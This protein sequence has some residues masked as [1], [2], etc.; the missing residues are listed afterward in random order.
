MLYPY[1]PSSVKNQQRWN[2]GVL[3]PLHYCETHPD[4]ESSSMQTECLLRRNASTRITV[5]LAFLQVVER[6]VATRARPAGN[7][8]ESAYEFV[9]RLEVDERVY[10][11]WKEAAERAFDYAGLGPAD[12]DLRQVFSF[13]CPAEETIEDLSDS[14]N[15]AAGGL[16]RRCNR[17]NGRLEIVLTPGRD[18]VVKVTV[19]AENLTRSEQPSEISRDGALMDALV[20]A[21]LIMG[22]EAGEF[23]SLTDPPACY[24]DLADGCVNRGVWPVLAGEGASTVLASPIILYDHPQIA[25]ESPGDL[26][27]ATEID[28][29][30]SLRIL[31]L[32]DDEKREMRD[33][34]PRARELL[35][36]TE[37]IS[38]VQFTK[39]HGVLHG[40][41]PLE[42]ARK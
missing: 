25:A 34:D 12:L 8:G 9:H 13:D 14:R 15:Q 16:V 2:F 29:I 26:F 28:E 36:R 3:F 11:P 20:S 32:T 22:V 35:E 33:A 17:L 41:A 18:D 39:L 21:H 1:R 19:R 30:L 37:K 27:D 42:E 7:Q 38:D 23:L 4:S 40:L 10:Q 24:Q 6:L 5:R 31:T